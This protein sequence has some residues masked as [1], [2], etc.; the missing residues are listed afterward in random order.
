[1]SGGAYEYRCHVVSA[2]AA[3][4][5]ADAV[6]YSRPHKSEYGERQEPYPI[7]ITDAYLRCA[8]LLERASK[9]AHDV[10]WFQSGDYG[11][12]SFL[13]C[14]AEWGGKG[15]IPVCP[16]RY[17]ARYGSSAKAHG[18]DN[19]NVTICGKEITPSWTIIDNDHAGFISC[20]K[21]IKLLGIEK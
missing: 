6:K 7:E 11:D 12:D 2:L 19:A 5:R 14:V 3:D 15:N 16:T 10:E 4:I 18:S 8:E 1:M 9:M 20:A 21:C 17:T 13:E